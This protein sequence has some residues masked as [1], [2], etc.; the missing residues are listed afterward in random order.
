[1][2]NKDNFQDWQRGFSEFSDAEPVP[3]PGS[4]SGPVLG[5][6]RHE[7]NPSAVLIFTKAAL[8][9]A[10]VG[11][12]TMLACPQFGF[13]FSGS[14]GILHYLMQYGESVCMLACGAIFTSFSLLVASF[15]LRPEEIRA[16][17]E[18]QVL[19]LAS[20]STLSIGVFLC[21]GASIVFT[22]GLV[23][24][25]GAIVGGAVSLEAGWAYRK[26]SMRRGLP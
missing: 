7:L 14:H 8:I 19:Q 23:W 4:V 12:I 2:E 18:N 9:H 16:F 25:L 1:M 3:V 5:R 15:V 10:I 13:S 6:I 21:A 17:R 26:F 24:A 22:L 11:A 20:L